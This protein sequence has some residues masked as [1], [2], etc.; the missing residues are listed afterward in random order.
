MLMFEMQMAQMNTLM[1]VLSNNHAAQTAA[2]PAAA[3]TPIA[4]PVVGL[5]SGS[6]AVPVIQNVVLAPVVKLEVEQKLPE[7]MLKLFKD[8]A[9]DFGRRMEKYFTVKKLR[10]PL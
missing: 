3:A 7:D 6:G 10:D 2:P 8:T 1:H 4:G 5:S 9:R